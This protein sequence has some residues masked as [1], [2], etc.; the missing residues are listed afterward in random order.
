MHSISNNSK[1]VRRW[2]DRVQRTANLLAL[3][4]IVNI[5]ACII[6]GMISLRKRDYTGAALCALAIV[7]VEGEGAALANLAREAGRAEGFART[8]SRTVKVIRKLAAARSNRRSTTRA[9]R[10][11]A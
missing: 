2:E 6:S 5:P 10:R 1:R 8:G 11:A 7:P 3:I 4:P 9:V